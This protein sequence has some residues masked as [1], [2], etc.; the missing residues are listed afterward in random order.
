MAFRWS[1]LNFQF[2]MLVK[3]T[4]SVHSFLFDSYQICPVRKKIWLLLKESCSSRFR[5]STPYSTFRK[6]LSCTSLIRFPEN[7]LP[8]NNNVKK[9]KNVSRKECRC[10]IP[11][12][13]TTENECQYNMPKYKLSTLLKF[14]P[15][16]NT[17]VV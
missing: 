1:P 9:M 6:E 12:V 15:L 4:V 5:S 14:I 16:F 8:C 17:I 11:M 3:L 7:F 2:S 10:V 13:L